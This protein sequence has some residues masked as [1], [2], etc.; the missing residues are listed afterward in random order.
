MGTT[1]P[2]AHP[3]DC[4]IFGLPHFIYIPTIQTRISGPSRPSDGRS[5][6]PRDGRGCRLIRTEDR[7]GS[8]GSCMHHHKAQ[9]RASYKTVLT[10]VRFRQ[11]PDGRAVTV[12]WGASTHGSSQQF[13]KA[14]PRSL[15]LQAW[16]GQAGGQVEVGGLLRADVRPP[17]WFSRQLCFVGG[18]AFGERVSSSSLIPINRQFRESRNVL[19]RQCG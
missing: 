4:F 19:V 10:V 6:R 16:W 15:W 12:A 9:T 13:L 11:M 14:P 7:E 17:R 18:K 5:L 3:K 1:H 8:Y 2:S